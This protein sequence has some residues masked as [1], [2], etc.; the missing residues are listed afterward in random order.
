MAMQPK[1]I[2]ENTFYLCTDTSQVSKKIKTCTRR[3][4]EV[5]R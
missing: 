4:R 2:L 3:C 5:G 1:K